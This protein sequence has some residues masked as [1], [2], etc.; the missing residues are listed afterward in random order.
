M[1][2]TLYNIGKT[3]KSY[4][5]RGIEDYCARIKHFIDFSVID[6]PGIKSGIKMPPEIIKKKEG[7]VLL[8]A[9]SKQEIVILLDETGTEMNSRKFA[10]WLNKLQLQS[11]KQVAFVSGGAFGFSQ[12]IYNLAQQ[13]I[14]LSKLTLTHQMVRLVFVEQLYRACTILKGMQYHND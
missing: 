1:K 14:S 10:E 6:I 9:L 8:K 12:E 2:F 7:E 13:K 11:Y 4:L 3:D 5:H